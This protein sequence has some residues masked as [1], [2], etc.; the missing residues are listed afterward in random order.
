MMYLKWVGHHR[1]QVLVPPRTVPVSAVAKTAEAIAFNREGDF[2]PGTEADPGGFRRNRVPDPSRIFM[3]RTT[4]S[5][6][7]LAARAAA[8]PIS[9]IADDISGFYP[10]PP[11]RMGEGV[12]AGW[13]GR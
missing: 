2:T 5:F 10:L 3:N 13:S 6:F 4:A 1:R 8:K 12:E 11:S 9:A 7:F